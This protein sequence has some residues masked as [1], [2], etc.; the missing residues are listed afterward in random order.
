MRSVGGPWNSIIFTSKISGEPPGIF[1]FGLL[2]YP[3]S[4]AMTS[5]RIPPGFI[6]GM[7]SCQPLMSP[8]SWNVT[9]FVLLSKTVPS[10]IQPAY[11]MVTSA[12][13]GQASPSPSF[14]SRHCTPSEIS[15][16]SESLV[17]PSEPSDIVLP[18]LLLFEMTS[19]STMSSTTPITGTRIGARLFAG[20][21]DSAGLLAAMADS[22]CFPELYEAVRAAG[23][24]LHFAESGLQAHG[25]ESHPAAA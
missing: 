13:G 2:P 23:Q 25:T 1:P 15:F 11:S 22:G 6:P 4:G 5:L 19:T 18:A 9:G 20:G 8:P 14:K 3:F 17:E 21:V 10:G 7:P 24:P 16:R 12:P